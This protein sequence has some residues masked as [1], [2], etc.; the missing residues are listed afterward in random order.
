MEDLELPTQPIDYNFTLNYIDLLDV[1]FSQDT[2]SIHNKP[3]TL[4]KIRCMNNNIKLI[5]S[6]THENILDAN[7][8]CDIYVSGFFGKEMVKDE[9]ITYK[10]PPQIPLIEVV[11]INDEELLKPYVTINNRR[12]YQIYLLLYSI[13]N[14]IFDEYGKINELFIDAKYIDYI[15]GVNIFLLV[16]LFKQ[17]LN[18]LGIIVGKIYIPV[19]IN[20]KTSIAPEYLFS[21]EG[22][23]TWETFLNERIKRQNL[24][25]N[26]NATK[27][28]PCPEEMV[29]EYFKNG[30]PIIPYF[31]TKK[32]FVYTFP[33]YGQSIE[34]IKMTFVSTTSSDY[35]LLLNIFGLSLEK[36]DSIIGRLD[37]SI[38]N[39]P[40]FKKE[41]PNIL[42]KLGSFGKLIDMITTC[43]HRPI[44]NTNTYLATIIPRDVDQDTVPLH[45]LS[46]K[47]TSKGKL[48]RKSKHRSKRKS[49]HRSKHTSKH[50]SK[51]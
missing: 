15:N 12:L 44:D 6:P 25:C 8:Y 28:Q 4:D 34:P 24:F 14:I 35:S 5:F 7:L 29:V 46:T 3:N 22:P 38:T 36:K 18:R 21:S 41:K 33:S 30:S 23:N 2:I 37:R 42:K 51:L 9:E 16:D 10:Y 27:T 26:I 19:I 11:D 43:Y 48:K 17:R 40:T 31:G 1:N 49:K 13:A 45:K 20:K 50:T 39:N 32:G 47:L